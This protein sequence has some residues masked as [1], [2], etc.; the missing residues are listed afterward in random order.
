MHTLL[1]IERRKETKIR[2][3]V[4]QATLQDS[5]KLFIF[6][7]AFHLLDGTCLPIS[8]IPTILKLALNYYGARV[9]LILLPP[10]KPRTPSH[11]V[12]ADFESHAHP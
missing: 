10:H 6:A 7:R 8:S 1:L 12:R 5:N 2:G 9:F 3:T 11:C 4:V